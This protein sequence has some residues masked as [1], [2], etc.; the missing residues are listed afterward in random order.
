M[1][2]ALFVTFSLLFPCA[3]IAAAPAHAASYPSH[4]I[5]LVVPYGPGGSTDL[6]ARAIGQKLQVRLAQPVVVVNKEGGS[7]TV[8]V[9]SVIQANPDGY[10]LLLGYTSE[11]VV[12]PQIS[13]TAKY[14]IDD[15]EP[16][17]VTG[18][19]PVVLIVSQKV[20]A[21]TM[22]ELIEELRRSPGHYTFGGGLGTPSHIMGSWLNQL[23][24][25]DTM[26]VPYRSGAQSVGDVIGGHLDMFY[27][28]IAA[29]KPAIDSGKVKAIAITG[30]VRA[31]V[32]PKVPTFKEVGL[33]NFELASWTVLLAPKGTPADVIGSLRTEIGAVLQDPEVR[34]LLLK[35]GVEP[36]DA[37]DAKRF[38]LAEQ[39]KFGRIVRKLG[40]TIG[41]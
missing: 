7:G 41:Q 3:L 10:T 17:A 15:F 24:D 32:L 35:Q 8:G 16:I 37:Q 19:V 20:K 11:M 31:S 21:D 33:S 14:S 4:T 29:A 13:A 22:P 9:R 34:S 6:I 40:I 25:L 39:D 28:G 27:S 1:P 38:L 36:S 18:I 5:E 2:K 12:M 26:Y 23:K 30:D